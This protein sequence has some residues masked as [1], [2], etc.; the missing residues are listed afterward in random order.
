MPR[1]EAGTQAGESEEGTGN[2]GQEGRG[3][4]RESGP[5]RKREGTREPRQRKE[6]GARAGNAEEGT[7]SPAGEPGR[8][9]AG[10]Q[11]VEPRGGN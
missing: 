7:G 3:G 9:E 10:V 6:L 2:L 5:Q 8:R 1:R 4:K 11:A